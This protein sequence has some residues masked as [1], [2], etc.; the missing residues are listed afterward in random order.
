[1]EFPLATFC[2]PC[3]KIECLYLIFPTGPSTQ[4][5]EAQH[6]QETCLTFHSLGGG[7][8]QMVLRQNVSYDV[9]G[10]FCM[11]SEGQTQQL[12]QTYHATQTWLETVFHSG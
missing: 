9:Y 5:A 8:Q 3:F 11:E 2:H 1:M 12:T 10:T 6:L 7:Q 4:W